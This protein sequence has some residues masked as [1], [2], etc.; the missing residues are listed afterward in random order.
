MRKTKRPWFFLAQTTAVELG[1]PRIWRSSFIT[2]PILF[3]ALERQGRIVRNS[4][5]VIEEGFLRPVP[6]THFSTSTCF[7]ST[8]FYGEL[9][10]GHL[11]SWEVLRTGL[12]IS[13]PSLSASSFYPTSLSLFHPTAQNHL[14]QAKVTSRVGFSPL[15][16]QFS[17]AFPFDR[18]L[19]FSMLWCKI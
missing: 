4:C 8:V 19:R 3:P 16:E 7:A 10:A 17:S 9:Q 6:K 18:R 12:N 14:W 5:G 2:S 1:K 11:C 15:G 13:A